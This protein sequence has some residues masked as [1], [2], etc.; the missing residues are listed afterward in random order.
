M[1]RL[2][3]EL[4]DVDARLKAEGLRLAEEWR[5][6]KVAINLGRHQ[7]DLDNAK[8]K[9]SLEVSREACSRALEEAH[10]A[11]RRR[12]AAEKLAWEL[13]AWSASLEQQVEAHKAALASLKGTPAEE[14]ELRRR[15]EALALEAVEHSLELERLETRER[16][17][18][19]AE[20][21]VGAREAKAQE[22]VDRRVAEVCAGLEGWHDLELQLAKTEAAGRA[23][24][25]R[26]RLAEVEG[27]KEAE[28]LSLQKRVDD[29]EAVAQQNR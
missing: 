19:Q 27:R 25:L 28:L 3:D 10:E 18:A 14:E 2:G 5:K 9:E 6:L 4:A 8:A 20:D 17:V 26:P 21:V 22:E 13:Q 23:A 12:E 16:Q 11:D 1:N 29:A 7:R 15:E 24:A